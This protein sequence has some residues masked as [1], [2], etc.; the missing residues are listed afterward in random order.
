MAGARH[1][2]AVG[3][4]GALVMTQE[5]IDKIRH[6]FHLFQIAALAGVLVALVASMVF[7]L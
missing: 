4:M 7:G 1:C 3:F 6:W 5:E 2:C